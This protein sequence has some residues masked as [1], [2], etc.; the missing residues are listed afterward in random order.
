MKLSDL[1]QRLC[2]LGETRGLDWPCYVEVR[3]QVKP[4]TDV[5]TEEYADGASGPAF[6]LTD[7][8]H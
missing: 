6:V 5:I 4:L 7:V 8:A 3:G 1:I 2:W